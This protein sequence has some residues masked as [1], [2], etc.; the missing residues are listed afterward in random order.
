[1]IRLRE[2]CAKFYFTGNGL[3][4]DVP[5][6]GNQR[7]AIVA[8]P[9]PPT[10]SPT[11]TSQLIPCKTLQLDHHH[12]I[13]HLTSKYLQP[14]SSFRIQLQIQTLNAP[15]ER[16]QIPLLHAP[17]NLFSLSLSRANQ[18][19]HLPNSSLI[20]VLRKEKWWSELYPKYLP[21]LALRS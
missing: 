9:L 7:E 13:L 1:M 8:S 2:S 19:L 20:S 11:T 14:N 10:S 5:N 15:L 6:F 21:V 16:Y 12:C 3:F 17:S 4:V 18:A